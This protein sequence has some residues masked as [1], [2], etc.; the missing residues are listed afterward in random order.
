MRLGAAFRGR[1]VPL[2]QHSG[3]RLEETVCGFKAFIV[4]AGRG[5]K[6]VVEAEKGRERESVEK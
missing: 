4:M 3:S 5:A 1:L 6:R 2:L